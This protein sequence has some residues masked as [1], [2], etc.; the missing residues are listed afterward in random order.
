MLQTVHAV[1]I[2][3]LW[4][5]NILD[6]D[7]ISIKLIK[8]QLFLVYQCV[9]RHYFLNATCRHTMGIPTESGDVMHNNTQQITMDE[10]GFKF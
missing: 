10:N 8:F 9:Q 5:Q 7:R 4:F 2:T 6:F 1:Y 3:G